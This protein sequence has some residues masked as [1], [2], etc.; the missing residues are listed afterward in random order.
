M[1]A[2]ES[3][4]FMGLFVMCVCEHGS[5]KTKSVCAKKEIS[6]AEE[7]VRLDATTSCE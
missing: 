2:K 5:V 3:K 1:S 4:A 6:T 7:Q